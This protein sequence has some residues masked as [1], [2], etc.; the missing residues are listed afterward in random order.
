MDYRNCA[1]RL[2]RELGDRPL[3]DITTREI[4]RWK[5]SFRA[6]RRLGDGTVRKT[7]PSPRTIRKYLINLNGIFRRAREVYGI[8]ANPVIDVKRP[9]RIKSRQ[10]LGSNDFLE[11]AE[12]HALIAAAD[13][14]TDASI[15]PT[16][17]FCGSAPGRAARPLHPR[18]RGHPQVRRRANSA[19]G[20][21]GR[22]GADA[23]A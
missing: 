3:E 9:G 21:R 1:D 2:C 4:E 16:A 22:C 6:E 8:S 20:S 15:F 13:D 5:S 11:P 14:D 23:I 17:A 19:N 10:T 7:P 12:V 18:T